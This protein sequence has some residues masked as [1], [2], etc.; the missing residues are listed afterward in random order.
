MQMNRVD[1]FNQTEGM[2]TGIFNVNNTGRVDTRYDM[3]NR[4]PLF[5]SAKYLDTNGMQDRPAKTTLSSY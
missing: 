1:P 3:W 4:N 5:V 2:G